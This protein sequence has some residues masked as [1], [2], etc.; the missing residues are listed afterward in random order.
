MTA[1][2][3]DQIVAHFETG[4]RAFQRSKEARQALAH[5]IDEYLQKY[6][7]R[8]TPRYHLL[9]AERALSKCHLPLTKCIFQQESGLLERKLPKSELRLS[10]SVAISVVADRKKLCSVG[11]QF[12]S[13]NPDKCKML[14]EKFVSSLESIR[15]GLSAIA[16]RHE[17]HKMKKRAIRRIIMD[18]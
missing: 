15:D 1:P 11:T 13:F 10:P 3:L 14:E 16:E 12:T 9:E 2:T 8:P 4:T 6:E 5:E 18:S 17:K 7:K